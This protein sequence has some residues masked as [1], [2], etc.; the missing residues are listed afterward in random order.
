VVREDPAEDTEE[1][2]GDDYEDEDELDDDD[3]T[4]DVGRMLGVGI[5]EEDAYI[6]EEYY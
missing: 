2:N 5:D 6:E 4:E 1:G 3:E